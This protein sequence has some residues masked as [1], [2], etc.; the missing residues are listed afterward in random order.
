MMNRIKSLIGKIVP[1]A[2]VIVFVLAAIPASAVFADGLADQGE[3]PERSA[4]ITD[5]RVE[6]AWARLQQAYERQG[7][8]LEKADTFTG[9]VQELIDRMKENGKDTSSLQAAL[10]AFETEI[11]K[12]HSIY[13]SAKGIINSHKG[14]DAGGKV[15]DHDLAVETIKS[16]AEKLRKVHQLVGEPGKA[17]R[18]ALRNL[19]E[20]RRSEGVSNPQG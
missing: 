12:A 1:V 5:E 15:T 18:E 2:V 13:E 16:L 19:R 7:Q 9:K 4:K 11:K 14:F 17:L 20:T 6:Q 3:P 8:M 10:D